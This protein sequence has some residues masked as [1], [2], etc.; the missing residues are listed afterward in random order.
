[1]NHM[2]PVLILAPS[3]ILVLY[4][5]YRQVLQVVLFVHVFRPIDSS[6][7]FS[8]LM[9]RLFDPSVL[10][11]HQHFRLPLLPACCSF[12][13]TGHISY[14]QATYHTDRPHIIPTGHI[15]NRQATFEPDRPHISPTGHIYRLATYHTDRTHI[16]PT[17]HIS[18]RQATYH[19]DRPHIIPTGHI[20]YRT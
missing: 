6:K 20:S 3:S 11:Q 8:S 7:R 19:T 10:E 13:A 2:N 16:T 9:S 18:Y 1:M 4:S 12:R 5:T 15:S 14:R 17:G